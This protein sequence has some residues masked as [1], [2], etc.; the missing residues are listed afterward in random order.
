MQAVRKLL[1]ALRLVPRTASETE[2]LPAALEIVE[3]PAS[4]AGRAI[5]ATIILFFVIALA[6]AS[7]GSVD[8]I[9]TARGQIIPTGRT[10]V[11]Q[12]FETGVVRAIHVQDGERVK[13]GD[14]LIEID[15]TISEAERDRLQKEYMTAA[16]D[17][18][19]LKASLS[20]ADDPTVDFAPPDNAPPE[21]V[22]LQRS[23][24]TNQ[25]QEIRSK[26]ADLDQKIAKEQGN[27]TAVQSTIA[28]ITE[29]LPF[30]QKRADAR[31]L[32]ADKGIGSKLDA[33]SAQQD[34]IE[35][36]QE[37]KV[38]QGRLDEATAGVAS[39]KEERAEAEAEYKHKNLDDL[40]QAQQKASSLQEQLVQASEKYK[41][42]TLT[43]PVDGTVQ[44]L[45]VHTQG[46]VVT[47][48]QILL[49]VVPADSHLE[50]EAMVSNRDIGFVHEGQ[51]VAIKVDTFN[52]TK[53][54]LI[55]GKVTSVS[56]DAITRNLPNDAGNGEKQKTGGET[57]SSEPKG[58]ELVYAARISLDKTEMQVDDRLVNLTP[59]MAVTA[60]IKTGS[61]HV[62][63][64]L[65]SPIFKY[66]HDAL[67][68]R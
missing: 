34:L 19:R 56:Q 29:A 50:I 45:A 15:S 22:A 60:E 31:Q 65:L 66:K 52:F 63:E 27:Q 57:D 2:F 12:P 21:Q 37:L 24:L 46:G 44:Q 42:Q 54:G 47:P 6:W 8:I 7:F 18:A 14:V 17:A 38:Q 49:V 28:K 20:T 53:Y 16:L 39:L 62:I 68:E 3:T 30:L 35:H 33:Y 51:D 10:K 26:L 4:P 61:R 5:A 48:A 1:P 58:Q 11:I 9:A 32:L 67:T 13:A 36:Q 64:F 40:T 41:L 55:H 43:A 25:V 23:L 59:G